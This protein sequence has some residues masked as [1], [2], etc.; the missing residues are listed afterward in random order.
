M[1]HAKVQ[2]H[3]AGDEAR[4]LACIAICVLHSIVY[5]SLCCYSVTLSY[6]V[7]SSK[8]RRLIGKKILQVSHTN[9]V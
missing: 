4:R 9:D 8:S 5:S 7:E 1:A 6:T 3:D 2:V